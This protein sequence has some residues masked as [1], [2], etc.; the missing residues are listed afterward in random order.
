MKVAE[1][2]DDHALLERDVKIRPG[3]FAGFQVSAVYIRSVDDLDPFDVM[4]R[5]HG[6]ERFL[7]DRDPDAAVLR[8]RIRDMFF[9]LPVGRLRFHLLHFPAAAGDRAAAARGD[10]ESQSAFNAFVDL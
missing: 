5:G 10:F 2:A 3:L 8:F 6:M 9:Q 4:L 7:P 1:F